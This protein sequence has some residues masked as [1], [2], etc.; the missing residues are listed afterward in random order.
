MADDVY[1][2]Q[3]KGRGFSQH[4]ILFWMLPQFG[5]ASYLTGP[6]DL[7]N[8]DDFRFGALIILT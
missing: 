4:G 8:F 2:P 7:I 5:E 6:H 3:T 1:I